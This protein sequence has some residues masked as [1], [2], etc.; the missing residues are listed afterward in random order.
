[1]E[2]GEEL[3]DEDFSSDD[4]PMLDADIPAGDAKGVLEEDEP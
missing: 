3:E 2:S 1:M 4:D